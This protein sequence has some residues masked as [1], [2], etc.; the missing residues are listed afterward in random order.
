MM[1]FFRR[2]IHS[3]YG[4]VLGLFFLGAIALSFAA[5]D[6]EKFTTGGLGKSGDTAAEVGGAK[7]A[8]T[9]VESRVQRV[10]DGNRQDTPTLTIGQFLDAGAVTEIVGQM[11]NG[12][13]LG[14]FAQANGMQVSKKLV[15]AE[16]AGIPAFQ[17]ATGKFSQRMFTELLA[18]QKIS[19]AALREDISRQI[20]E[21]Q[22]LSPSGAGAQTPQGMMLPYASML[23][24]KR[25]GTVAILPSAAFVSPTR[26]DEAAIKRFYAANSDRF[27]LPEQRRMRYAV[28]DATRF[29]GKTAPSEAEIVQYYKA[30]TA[31]YAAS[32]KRVVRQL[33]LPT[34]S[35][36]KTVAAK[37]GPALTLEKAASAAG[38]ATTVLEPLTQP[39]FAGQTTAAAA[40]QVFGAAR[41]ALVGPVKTGLGWALFHVENV[42]AIPART[43]D[44]ARPQIV[45]ALTGTKTKQALADLS[46]SIDDQIGGG[47]TFDQI[48]KANG[49]TTVETPALTAQGRDVSAPQAQPDTALLPVV[50]A[51][52]AMEQDD[53]PQIVPLV[54]DQRIA[55][56]ALAQI[57]PAGPPPLAAIHADV[58]RAVALSAGAVKAKAAA[59]AVLKK[60]AGGTAIPAALAGV[61]VPLPPAQRVGAQRSQLGQQGAR[62]PEA[63]VTLFSMKIG[64]TRLLPLPGGQGYMV[65][66][67][68]SIQPGD[69][70]GNAQLLGATGQGLRG[71]LS[72]EYAQQFS[73]AIRANVGVKRNDTA[74]ARI[75]TDLRKSGTAQ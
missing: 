54:A 11:V 9:E 40:T 5:G 2:V 38:L 8:T 57:V 66:H 34:E 44:S 53:D 37:V 6:I 49:L 73:G 58:E 55:L 63:M 25:A 69:A 33:I 41:G 62:V 21:R 68:D 14:E 67:L 56:V 45:T 4:A 35:A 26:P 52:F 3:R 64:S 24:E 1:G 23:L 13:A 75:D 17:D 47:S 30:N 72:S 16:I 71:V 42:Q 20:I 32:E 15:D 60:I 43:L 50:T 61:G 7:L 29:A 36:A 18:R 39:A 46:N 59:D 19:E 27:A 22:L 28:I 12:L 74:L 10:F 31:Q 51:G 70:G 65:L 48:V